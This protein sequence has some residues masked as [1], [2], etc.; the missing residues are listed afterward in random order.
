M[1]KEDIGRDERTVAVENA[2]Y[3]WSYLVLSFGLLILTAY[4]SLARAEA[5]WDLLALV[6]LGGAVNAIYQGTRRVLN[7]QWIVATVTTVGIA[8]LVAILLLVVKRPR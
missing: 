1:S 5:S 3:R 2:G 6:L 8:A 7:K 4:R